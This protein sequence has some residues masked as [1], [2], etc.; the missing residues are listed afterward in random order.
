VLKK[1]GVFIGDQAVPPVFEDV[2]LA[3]AIEANDEPATRAVIADYDS[4]HPIWGFKRPSLIQHLAQTVP[5]FRNPVFIAVF[6]DVLSITNRNVLSMK[7]EPLKS[8]R[9]ALVQYDQVCD[10]LESKQPSALLLSNEKALLRPDAFVDEL[11]DW[12]GLEVSAE[13]RK[14][15][16]DAIV[17]DHPQYLDASRLRFLGHLDK[18]TPAHV[19]GWACI[20]GQTGPAKLE[21]LVNGRLFAT[22]VASRRRQDVQRRGV[23][24]TGMCGFRHEFRPEDGVATGDQVSVRFVLGGGELKGAPKSVE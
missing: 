22:V 12:L 16:Q 18:V 5:L 13:Q 17:V 24:P 7:S 6:R 8:L 23:H 15:A 9:Q 11:V 19:A 10:F 20:R 4:A 3:T 2:R 21:I 14:D 1:L